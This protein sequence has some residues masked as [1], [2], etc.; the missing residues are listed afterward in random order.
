MFLWE[1]TFLKAKRDEAKDRESGDNHL[2]LM[3]LIMGESKYVSVFTCENRKI[4]L[5][6]TKA[7]LLSACVLLRYFDNANVAELQK[8][9][10]YD[11]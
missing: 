9:I 10:M 8:K 5:S 4:E 3:K 6:M 1:S 7:G 11:L 2:K